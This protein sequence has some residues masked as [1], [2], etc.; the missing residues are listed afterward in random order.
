MEINSTQ[1]IVILLF[2]ILFVLLGWTA[3]AMYAS[4]APQEQFITVHEFDAADAYTYEDSHQLC[5]DRTVTNPRSGEIF[6]ELYAESTNGNRVEVKTERF[7]D[8]FQSGRSVVAQDYTL[9]EELEPGTYRYE[10][11]ATF[12][13]ASGRV[14]RRFKFTSEP[15][16]IVDVNEG[17]ATDRNPCGV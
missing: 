1:M 6:L 12:K 8:F 15:F 9:P 3:P 5:F 2:S 14:T 16:E 4:Y 17:A 11:V 7:E 10:I 13:L